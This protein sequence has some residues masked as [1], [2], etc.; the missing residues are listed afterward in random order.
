MIRK[1]SP[2]FTLVELL[3]VMAVVSIC[4]AI[5]MPDIATFSSGYKLRAAAREV[6]SDLQFTRLLAVKENKA[7]RVIFGS[8]S[9]Q[10]IRLSDGSVAKS[11]SFGPEY[12]DISL[13]N[14][15]IDFDPRGL[16]NGSTVTVANPKGTKNVSVAPTG[17]VAIE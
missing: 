4:L 1:Y 2:G 7:F 8:D 6:A 15:A 12:P 10:V 13:T 16:S 14:A 17:R 11:R 3:I 5:A 9:Y